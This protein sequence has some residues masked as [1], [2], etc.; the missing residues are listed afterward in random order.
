M[1]PLTSTIFGIKP[2]SEGSNVC[3]AANSLQ[4]REVQSA[5]ITGLAV[6]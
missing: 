1:T 3:Q 5:H 2:L 4:Y 6:F